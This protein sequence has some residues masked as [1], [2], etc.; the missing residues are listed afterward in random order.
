VGQRHGHAGE[1][2]TQ[3]ARRL[4]GAAGAH[5]GQRREDE[6]QPHDE[7]TDANAHEEAQTVRLRIVHE[8]ERRDEP[9]QHRRYIHVRMPGTQA[10]R[11]VRIGQFQ[12]TEQ[13]PR[14]RRRRLVGGDEQGQRRAHEHHADGGPRA[15]PVHQERPLVRAREEAE[16]HGRE[17]RA[18]ALNQVRG[19]EGG[20]HKTIA[21][22][23]LAEL[24]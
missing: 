22:D 19:E 14:H 13:Q 17:Q 3:R 15:G 7:R 10:N 12:R 18:G 2:A 21:T 8:H 6:R 9:E 16:Q 20:A 24:R 5:H 1:R 11:A 4:G 23:D